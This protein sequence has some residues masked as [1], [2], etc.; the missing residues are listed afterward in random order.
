MGELA[1]TAVSTTERILAGFR[2]EG[3]IATGYKEI[4]VRDIVRLREIA[5][6]K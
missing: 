1:G 6:G 4:T 3:V 5:T 2:E